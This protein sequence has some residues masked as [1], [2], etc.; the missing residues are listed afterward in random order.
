MVT[1]RQLV[2]RIRENVGCEWNEETVDTFKVG[3]PDALVSGV[4]TRFL[5][6]VDV[7]RRARAE[8]LN[9]VITHEPTFYHHRDDT[10]VLEGDP[11]LAASGLA[12]LVTFGH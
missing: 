12:P 4:A 7:L 3:D 11:I 5:A 1:A 10:T 9:F 2:E 8:G 6:T